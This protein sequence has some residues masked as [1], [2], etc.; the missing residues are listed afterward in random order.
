M[1]VDSK[2]N[3]LEQFPKVMKPYNQKHQFAL[4]R[5]LEDTINLPR[6]QL[7]CFMIRLL[8]LSSLKNLS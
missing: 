2:G 8:T 3:S 5:S 7:K 1:S 4:F 6:T